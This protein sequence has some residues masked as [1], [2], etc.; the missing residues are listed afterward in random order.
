MSV[1]LRTKNYLESTSFKNMLLKLGKKKKRVLKCENTSI[2]GTLNQLY[3]I[4][5]DFNEGI[6]FSLFASFRNIR[7]TSLKTM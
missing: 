1:F 4:Y 2:K 5:L 7:N 6:P 3:H